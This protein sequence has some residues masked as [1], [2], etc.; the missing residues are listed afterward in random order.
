MTKSFTAATVLLLRDEG[1][2]ASGRPRGDPRPRAAGTAPVPSRARRPSRCGTCCRCPRGS[3]AT[4]PGAIVSRTSTS[5]ASPS[6]SR[7]GRR[8]RGC[9]ARSSSTRTS[10]TRSSAA[11]SP[12]SRDRSIATSSARDC[13]SRW[14]WPRPDTTRAT[15]PAERLATGYVRRD[16]AFVEEPFAGYGAFASMGGLFST[17]RDLA[18]WV[19]GFAASVRH[20]RRGGRAIRS[21]AR[22]AWRCSRSTARSSRS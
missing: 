13:S 5:A 4:I 16:D 9:R 8:S 1:H 10:G 22:P 18:R 2:L 21:R 17:V 15:F 7:A 3:R 11:S 12:T 6:S 14:A 19:D 20:Q